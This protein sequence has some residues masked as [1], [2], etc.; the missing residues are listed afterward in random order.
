[1]NILSKK[2]FIAFNTYKNVSFLSLT[3]T[4]KQVVE[5]NFLYKSQLFM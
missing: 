1:M 4:L 2:K 3:K 5:K